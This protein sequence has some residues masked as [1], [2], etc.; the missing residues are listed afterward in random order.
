M[1]TIVL[2]KQYTEVI[3]MSGYPKAPSARL[4]KNAGAERIS[5]DAVDVLTD[6]V[7]AYATT[8]A[9]KATVYA[10][11]AGR[12]TVLASDVKLALEW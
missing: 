3:S 11:H 1:R 5:A 7:D 9:K 2:I 10:R 6:A 4:A 8:I 12:K